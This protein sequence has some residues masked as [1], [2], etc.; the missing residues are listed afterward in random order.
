MLSA[1]CVLHVFG[2]VLFVYHLSSLWVRVC[3]L[4]VYAVSE[5][6]V[7]SKWF[8]ILRQDPAC[9]QN[10]GFSQW[11]MIDRMYH[12][13]FGTILNL[14]KFTDIG[15]PKKSQIVGNASDKTIID[16]TFVFRVKVF[17]NAAHTLSYRTV[18]RRQAINWTSNGCLWW[19]SVWG[20]SSAIWRCQSQSTK[21][22]VGLKLECSFYDK[23][24]WSW[25]RLDLRFSSV[26]HLML[27]RE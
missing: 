4:W 5:H 17:R 12:R 1:W 27:F 11:K 3:L 6:M 19:L 13:E 9:F 26:T 24:W 8:Q 10:N 23:C 2:C 20:L 22:R 15:L 16:D 25:K 18:W 7:N 14:F 21:I